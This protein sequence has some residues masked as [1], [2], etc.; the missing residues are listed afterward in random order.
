MYPQ[1]VCI[2][3][4]PSFFLIRN[5]VYTKLIFEYIYLYLYIVC[6]Y[7]STSNKRFKLRPLYNTSKKKNK[8]NKQKQ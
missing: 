5:A 8:A 4:S 1:I 7:T 6:A 3:L 2:T